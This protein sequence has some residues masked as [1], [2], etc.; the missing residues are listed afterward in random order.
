MSQLMLSYP[1]IRPTVMVLKYIL[2]QRN[3]NEAYTGGIGSFVIFNMVYAYILFLIRIK[4]IS[5]ISKSNLITN[6]AEELCKLNYS[7]YFSSKEMQSIHDLGTFFFGFLNFYGFEFDYKNYGIS[8]F[9]IGSFFVKSYSRLFYF[10]DKLCIVNI[11]DPNQD[12]CRTA[13]NYD[14]IVELFQDLIFKIYKFEKNLFASYD[15]DSS[16]NNFANNNQKNENIKDA[17]DC[18]NNFDCNVIEYENISYID[19]MIFYNN[20]D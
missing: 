9:G 18:I 15:G 20:D 1:I 19:K 2:R 6:E 14:R 10:S 3:L 16:E 13:F 7:K 11:L 12:I 8:N 17:S 4:K 5:F